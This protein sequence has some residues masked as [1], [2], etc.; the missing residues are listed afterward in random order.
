MVNKHLVKEL[1]E[2]GL[3]NRDI[4]NELIK[5]DGSIQNIPVISPELKEIYKTVWELSQGALINMSAERGPFID[6]SQSLNL[7]FDTPTVGKLSTAHN[8]GWRLGL[9]TGQYYLRSQSVDN[10]AKH[11]AIDMSTEKKVERPVDSQFECFG[12]SS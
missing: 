3:W 9:K 11:L 10:K 2:I 5:S 1:E 7:F 4:L 12:C 6:Q 8:L